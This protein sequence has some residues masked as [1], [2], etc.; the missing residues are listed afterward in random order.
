MN[1][2]AF[3]RLNMRSAVIVSAIVT[4]LLVCLHTKAA[5]A[6]FIVVTATPINCGQIRV[7]DLSNESPTTCT[8]TIKN[9]SVWHHAISCR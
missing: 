7:N 5:Q 6:D 9:T 2:L 4:Y 1:Q 3:Q 8:V